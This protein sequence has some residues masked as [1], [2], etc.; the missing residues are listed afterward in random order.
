MLFF[1]SFLFFSS[2]AYQSL[3]RSLSLYLTY[4]YQKSASVRL[5]SLFISLQT[6]IR[7][8]C[9]ISVRQ[10]DPSALSYIVSVQLLAF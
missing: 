4:R 2:S 8:A 5:P 10:T 3:N 1:F 9:E 7:L 6:G